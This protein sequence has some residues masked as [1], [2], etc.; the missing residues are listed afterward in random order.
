M[1]R[2]IAAM[3]RRSLRPHEPDLNEL[4]ATLRYALRPQLLALYAVVYVGLALR[5]GNVF[6]PFRILLAL[7]PEPAFKLL[8]GFVEFVESLLGHVVATAG[9][10]GVLK[11]VLED[12]LHQS[13]AVQEP[14]SDGE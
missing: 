2:T 8:Y 13:D 4:D 7:T 1:A 5:T 11:T 9:L 14:E 12:A 10:V 3:L 6:D